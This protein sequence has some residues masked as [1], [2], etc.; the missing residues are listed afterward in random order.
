MP[1]S[2]VKAKKSPIVG[3]W[4]SVGEFGSQV[5]YHVRK[6]GPGY[7][8]SARDASD[9]ELADVFEEKWDAGARAL[10]FAV[11]W[12]STGRFLRCRIQL[13]EP[14]QV[15][16]TYTFTDTEPLVR[17]D[18]GLTSG[19]RPTAGKR[20]PSNHRPRPAVAHP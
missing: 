13:I 4:R 7:S 16:L 9:G 10:T 20:P 11:H 14:D 15:E 5:E 12:K 3:I 6:K 19:R 2:S 1:K 8:V 18:G 17:K